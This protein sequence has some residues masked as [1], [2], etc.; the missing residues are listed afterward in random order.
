MDENTK[1]FV[2]NAH[3]KSIGFFSMPRKYFLGE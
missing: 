3:K 2:L 1:P